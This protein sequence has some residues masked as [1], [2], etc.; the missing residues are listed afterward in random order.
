MSLTGF[1]YISDSLNRLQLGEVQPK[2][3]NLME[4]LAITLLVVFAGIVLVAPIASKT[5]IPVNVAEIL[6]GIII[7]VSLFDL[8]PKSPVIDFISSFGLGYLMFLAGLEVDFEEIDHRALKKTVLVA[9]ASVSIPFLA[10]VSLSLW[11]DVNALLLGTIFCTTS[12][13][14]ILP[15]FRDPQLAKQLSNMLLSSVVLVD[16]MSIFLLAVALATMRGSL[17][18]SFLYSFIV[19]LT[20][21]ALPLSLSAERVRSKI[22][23]T[24]VRGHNLG[25]DTEVK[26]T[27][28]LIFLLAA[29]SIWLGFHYIIGTF[30]A[31]LIISMVLPKTTL[32][33]KNLRSWG[34]GFF[35]PMFFIFIGAKVDLPVLFSNVRNLIILLVIIAVGILSKLIGVGLVAKLSGLSLKKSIACGL[36]H[37]ARLSLVVAAADIFVELGLVDESLFSMFIILAITSAIMA[38][39]LGRYVLMGSATVK[40]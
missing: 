30:I 9:V 6:F 20:L 22:Q 40:T 28:A 29:A 1:D 21:F 10:G 13:G 33:L 25:P 37:S 24:L 35:I 7:G 4:L 18:I 15:L 19:M 38:P 27:F 31:G 34:W 17:G 2:I 14:L 39:V 12:I 3:N 32:V 36:F 23:S 16:I 11:I 5:G 26:A 8:I